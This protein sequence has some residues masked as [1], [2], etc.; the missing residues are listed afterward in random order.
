M[1]PNS[2]TSHKYEH[3]PVLEATRR[4]SDRKRTRRATPWPLRIR[5]GRIFLRLR[6]GQTSRGV[7]AAQPRAALTRRSASCP[8]RLKSPYPRVALFRGTAHSMTQKE[9]KSARDAS[10]NNN[11]NNNA[12]CTISACNQSLSWHS[13]ITPLWPRIN[14]SR[15]WNSPES[16]CE[17]PMKTKQN[18]NKKSGKSLTQSR[19]GSKPDESPEGNLVGDRSKVQHRGG[20]ETPSSLR[21]RSVSVCEGVRARARDA[22]PP[23][24]A[25]LPPVQS[26]QGVN[27]TA[28]ERGWSSI[29]EPL[30]QQ[31]PVPPPGQSHGTLLLLRRLLLCSD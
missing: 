24:L 27:R 3:S 4:P 29:P 16:P 12:A 26:S 31:L 10:T 18:K 2:T 14:I 5:T 15:F 8:R 13:E 11:N 28:A 20:G 30:H 17:L 21:L 7:H 23:L 9:T 1:T 25:R 22:P 19:S 6:R